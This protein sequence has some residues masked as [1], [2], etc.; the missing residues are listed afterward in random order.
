MP[1]DR[2][3]PKEPRIETATVSGT[4]DLYAIEEHGRRSKLLEV[5]L[6]EVIVYLGCASRFLRL[7]HFEWSSLR[8][9]L[10]AQQSLWSVLSNK[11]A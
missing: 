1:T 2:R 10:W 11:C 9:K 4:E 8:L 7:D 3:G 6:D 5:P